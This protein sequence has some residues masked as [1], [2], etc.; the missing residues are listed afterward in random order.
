[1]REGR[2]RRLLP[3]IAAVALAAACSPW[4]AADGSSPGRSAA[5][6]EKLQVVSHRKSVPGYDRRCGRGHGCV[7]GPAWSDDGDVPGGGNSCR[8]RDDVLKAQLE[9]VRTKPGTRGCVVVEGDLIDPYT[10]A[11][12]HFIK[13]A[14]DRVEIDHVLPLAANWDLGASTWTPQQRLN[15]AN[16]T[17]GLLATSAAVN[18]A[19]G[20]KTPS[21]W[22]PPTAAGR[23]T[24]AEVYV[25][26]A[27][28]YQLPVTVADRDALRRMLR[29][30]R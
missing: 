23:C 30:C 20:D 9:N 26:V 14:A 15:F 4:P 6:L 13:S 25:D 27:T 28:I 2:T 29:S 8:T 17:R 18:R 11:A 3:A 21:E 19:K 22:S 24:Y 7:F 1:M 5:E 12:V 16:D 10:G